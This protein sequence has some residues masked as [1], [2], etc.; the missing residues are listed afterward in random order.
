[1]R[2]YLASSRDGTEVAA[3]YRTR[4]N[5]RLRLGIVRSDGSDLREY[6]DVRPQDIC[7]SYD[8]P[9]LA[10]TVYKSPPDTEL[11]VMDLGTKAVTGEINPRAKLTSQCWSPDD[12][13]IVYQASGS[14]QV[15]E[16]GQ[17]KSSVRVLGN[18]EHPTWSPD[19]NW[20]AFLDHDTYYAIRPNG[21]DRKKLFHRGDVYTGLWW[22][23]DSRIVGYVALARLALDDVYQLRVRML[24][25]NSDDWVAE[26]QIA[27]DNFQWVVNKQLVEHPSRSSN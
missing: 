14:V 19:G 26:G 10:M 15:Y 13:R 9:K 6:Q 22:S 3:K 25:D 5:M 16:L 7:W 8:K 17:D 18:G 23:P 1:V 21:Q 12:K 11:E 2:D 20:I 27:G 24:E 4:D